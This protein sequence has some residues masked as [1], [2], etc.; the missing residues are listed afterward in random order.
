MTGMRT[1]KQQ[2]RIAFSLALLLII[3]IYVST[4]LLRGLPVIHP[5]NASV[6]LQAAASQSGI[7][8][9]G[10]S[11]SASGVV[12]SDILQ[13]NGDQTPLPTASTAKI[14]TALVVLKQKPIPAGQSGPIITLGP[15]DV[16]FYNSTIAQNGSNVPVQPGEQLSE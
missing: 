8:W 13:S 9:P 12:G 1:R 14:I 7:R 11:Q 6:K 5:D 4:A 15:A 2:R 16:A 3:G 10:E